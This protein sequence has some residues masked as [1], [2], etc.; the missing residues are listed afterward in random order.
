MTTSTHSIR[1]VADLK[2]IGT[3]TR[4]RLVRSLIGETPPEKQWRIVRETRSSYMVVEPEGLPGN[5]SYLN[6]P[7]ARDFRPTDVG[8][9]IYEGETLCAS[10]SFT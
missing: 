9:D 8:F 1:T 2:R 7:K 10:Y 3:G 4:L 6:W 5:R